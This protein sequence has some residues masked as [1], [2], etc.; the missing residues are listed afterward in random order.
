MPRQDPPGAEN[1]GCVQ[2]SPQKGG[3]EWLDSPLSFMPV[4]ESFGVKVL[5]V[6]PYRREF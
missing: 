5:D 3:D 1:W 2:V 4:Q 6:G